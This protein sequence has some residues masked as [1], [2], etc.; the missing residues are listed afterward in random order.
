[1][2]SRFWGDATLFGIRISIVSNNEDA[3]N[4][5]LSVLAK[6]ETTTLPVP[7]VSSIYIVLIARQ[8]DRPVTDCTQIKDH[9]LYIVQDRIALHANGRRGRGVCVFSDRDVNG[10]AFEEAVRTIALF[11][12]AHADRTPVHASAIMIGHTAIV[13]AGKSGSG[14][15]SLA[16]AANRAGLPILSEDAVFVQLEPTLRVWALCTSIHVFA[17]DAPADAPGGTRIRS[18]GLKRAIPIAY[19]R[20]YA[21]RATLC[22]IARGSRIEFE[23]IDREEAVRQLTRALEPGFDYYGARSERVIRALATGGCWR[24]TLSRDPDE[25]IAKLLSD[26]SEPAACGQVV[27]AES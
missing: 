9:R 1:M 11:L 8:F 23:A 17:E 26:F 18:G 25:A 12:V 22:L 6:S 16:L 7:P 15:S 5:A 4:A 3:L 2:P 21:E 19:P 13:L 27:E 14:K 20:R 10:D 24:L